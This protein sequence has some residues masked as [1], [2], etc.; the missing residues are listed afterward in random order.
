MRDRLFELAAVESGRPQDALDFNGLT[1]IVGAAATRFGIGRVEQTKMVEGPGTVEMWCRQA[2]IE[3]KGT[4]ALRHRQTPVEVAVARHRRTSVV[5]LREIRIDAKGRIRFPMRE[6]EPALRLARGRKTQVHLRRGG[7]QS[8]V[9]E[10]VARIDSE[11]GLEVVDGAK[12]RGRRE[13][14]ELG[15]ALQVEF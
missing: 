9:G 15:T 6:I 2:R 1:W 11:R 10:R 5:R 7:R 8:S 14:R 12:R 3:R 13:A 4:I